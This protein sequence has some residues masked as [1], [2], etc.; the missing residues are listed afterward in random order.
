MIDLLFVLNSILLGAG[1]AMDAFSVSIGNG[2][3]EPD[4]KHG[5]MGLMAGCYAFFQFAMPMIGWALIHTI[6][7]IFNGLTK[8][9][10]WI[11][12][13]LLLFIGGK[14]IFESVKE[15]AQS[16]K[17]ASSCDASP[18]DESTDEKEK[19]IVKKLPFTMLVIQGVATS[20][21][22]LSVGLTISEYHIFA[23]LLASLIIAVVTFIICLVGLKIGKMVGKRLGVYAGILGG[24]ILVGIGIEI[25]VKGMFF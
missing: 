1:L 4:M 3:A 13:I 9:I 17:K 24:V 21:D 14:M 22:A 15:I 23:A 6:I 7:T 16:K 18:E 11:A 10:P 25:F 20:I 8:A 5:R 19:S 12:L 2:L